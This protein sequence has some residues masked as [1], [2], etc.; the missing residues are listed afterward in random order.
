MPASCAAR[1][2]RPSTVS[3]AS[4]RLPGLLPALRARAPR[5]LKHVPYI[6]AE[7]VVTAHPVA[8]ADRFVL[9]GAR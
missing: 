6:T 9:M 4:T 5:Y 7:P 2:S 3:T 8:D 1:A